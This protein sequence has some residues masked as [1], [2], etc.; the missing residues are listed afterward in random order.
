MKKPLSQSSPS[1][2]L[3]GLSG[4]LFVGGLAGGC[5]TKVHRHTHPQFIDDATITTNVKKAL[6]ADV[7]IHSFEIKVDTVK[8]V[9]QLSGF[10]NTAVQKAAAETDASS[11]RGVETVQ[12]GLILKPR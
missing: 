2:A 6:S 1:A 4:L 3:I 12:N 9:V 5:A 8:C 11:V 10:V 7:K